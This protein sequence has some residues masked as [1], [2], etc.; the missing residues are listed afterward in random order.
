MLAFAAFGAP[1]FFSGGMAAAEFVETI[2]QSTEYR[3]MRRQLGKP[4]VQTNFRR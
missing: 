3:G 4:A 2:H 1:A